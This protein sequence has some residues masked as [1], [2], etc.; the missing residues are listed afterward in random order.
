MSVNAR[1]ETKAEQALLAAYREVKSALPGASWARELRDEP[2][3]AFA[4]AGLPHRRLETWKWTDLRTLM[5][6]APPLAKPAPGAAEVRAFAGLDAYRLVFVNGFF[7]PTLSTSGLPEGV[8]AR[9]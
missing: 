9:G 3:G 7:A 8:E 5:R 1:I 6:E 4:E 2:T